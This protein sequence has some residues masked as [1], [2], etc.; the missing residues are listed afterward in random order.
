MLRRHST[1]SK[2]DLHR[3][4][5]TTSVRS[6]PLD[7]I[8]VVVA[9]RDAK[10]AA[11]QAFSRGQDRRSADMAL[12]PPQHGSPH[13]KENS[14]PTQHSL[15]N[16]CFASLTSDQ[17]GQAIGRRQSVRFVGPDSGLQTR[18]SRISMRT[19]VPGRD[20]AAPR[21]S[22]YRSESSQDVGSLQ[23]PILR[24]TQKYQLPDRTSS[25]GKTLLAPKPALRQDYL[26][27]LAPDHQQYT[28]EDDIASMPSSYRRV[29]KTRSMFT[30]RNSMRNSEPANQDVPLFRTSTTRPQHSTSAIPWSRLSFLSR[31]ENDLTPSTPILKAPK[32]MSFLKH[33]RDHVALTTP[34]QDPAFD[35]SPVQY[36]SPL[37][38]SL[39]SR[40]LPKPSM[41][42]GSKG[43]KIGQNLRKTLR[44]S[45]SN[46]A[47]PVSGTTTSIP[48]SIHG[49][50]RI[51]ARKM[52]SSIKSKFKNLFINKTDDD[53]TLPA[54]QI[55]AQRTHVSDLFEGNHFGPAT[56]EGRGFREGSAFS[57]VTSHVPSL[58]AVPSSERLHSRRGSIDSLGSEG[59]R[60]SD[61]KSRVTSWASTEVNTVIAHR[62]CD[63]SDDWERQR[64]SVITEHGLHAP[65][66]SFTRPK[67]SLQ[68]ITSQEELAPPLVMERLPPG[69]T[70][71]SERVYSALMKRMSE[72]QQRFTDILE[73]QRQASDNSDPFRTLS[74]PTS[75]D[76]SDSG[77][78]AALTH[79]HL[80][81]T[82][83]Q[84]APRSSSEVTKGPYR[85]G[86]EDHRPLS[87]PVQLTPR[88]ADVSASKPITDRSSAFFGS[89]TSHLFRTRSPWRR[90][91]QDAMGKDHTTSQEPI[92][93]A[94]D[95]VATTNA[96]EMADKRAD[97]TSNYS[98]D[99][100]IHK[101]EMKQEF[102]V[103]GI[104]QLTNARKSDIGHRDPPTYRPTGERIISTASSVDWKTRLSYDV[105]NMAKSP[106][107]PTKVSG[108]P[109]QVEYVVPTMP[110]SFGHG[111]VRE[112]AQIG[113]CEEDEYNSP[114]VRMPTHPTTPLGPIEPNVIKLTPQQRSVMQTTPPP[115]AL[116]PRE[117]TL[118]ASRTAVSFGEDDMSLILSKDAM[119]PRAS[120]LD[121]GGSCGT[122]TS[123]T[124]AHLQTP[125]QEARPI[126]QAKS[127]AHLQGFGRV[128]AEETGSP[129]PLGSPTVR[130]MRK[131]TAKLELN[132]T[133][134]ASTPGFST[135]FERQF[136][137][138]PRRLGAEVRAKENQ[139][140]HVEVSDGTDGRVESPMKDTQARGSKNM[141]D[142]FLNSRR[143]QREGGDGA[144]FV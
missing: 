35:H 132:S 12:F 83:D 23:R 76:S 55:E 38:H 95:S 84:E 144:A 64:L 86:V 17:D 24:D 49:S 79:A 141:V 39:R 26:E 71:D 131:T 27:A 53:A 140:P 100:Q 117:N 41:F 94:T 20:D 56:C 29:R 3:R 99:T 52:S 62:P 10:L 98:Q 59:R 36:V 70:V 126:R 118:P 44:H 28:P 37:H 48:M 88:D 15:T 109:S 77:G 63:G 5:S 124:V 9:Q 101:L 73:Q 93:N 122:F 107:S 111:H 130:L 7:H 97:S 123:T 85:L 16:D 43:S 120:P 67:L 114:A 54:Q 139:S 138:F 104:C 47:L 115:V 72:T 8:S 50:M 121:S 68:I 80:P 30:T 6:V 25:C 90:S 33:H 18:A 46:T 22:I 142:M 108:R 31:K 42:F 65:S 82:G 14:S 66:P 74:P 19:A 105:A 119:R 106:P 103:E 2:S 21:R 13:H 143:R 1:K 11:V 81:M 113:V 4:R 116:L 69:S 45:S 75:D 91:L 112:A 34:D 125:A 136:G 92:V 89:P 61:E 40:I 32:S 134:T 135:A 127:L 128:R 96:N 57:R 58:H 78:P 87:P 137:S 102:P 51:K 129:R 60:V 110:R 133:S